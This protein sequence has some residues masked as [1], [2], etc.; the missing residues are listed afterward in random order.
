MMVKC[1]P[2]NSE[3]KVL[4]ENNLCPY[5]E[6]FPKYESIMCTSNLLRT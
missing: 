6:C 2:P 4:K 1:T 5:T 3:G